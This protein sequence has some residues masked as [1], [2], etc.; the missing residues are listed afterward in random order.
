MNSLK[1]FLGPDSQSYLIT[2]FI[3]CS[4]SY[5]IYG[6]T[7][8]CG[9]LCVGTTIRP[10]RERF[11]EHRL[12]VEKGLPQYNVSKHFLTQHTKDASLLKV[13][14]IKSIPLHIPEGERFQRLCARET[15]WIYELDCLFPKGLNLDLYHTLP[16]L[17]KFY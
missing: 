6:L 9:K 7:C 16:L 12:S 8:A 3:T 2:G 14:G 5:V 11:D 1:N 10:L 17:H 15:F 13:F 4:S